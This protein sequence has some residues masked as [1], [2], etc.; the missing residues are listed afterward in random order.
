MRGRT[1]VPSMEASVH[2]AAV[3]RASQDLPVG[4]PHWAHGDRVMHL[5]LHLEEARLVLVVLLVLIVL[6]V[7]LVLLCPYPDA[8]AAATALSQLCCL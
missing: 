1:T 2:H 3:P 6:L 4:P 8:A 5:H 7:L